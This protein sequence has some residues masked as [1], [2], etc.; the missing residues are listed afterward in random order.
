MRL[1]A[2][3]LLLASLFAPLSALPA[4]ATPLYA[5]FANPPDSA[6]PRTWWHWMDG[7]VSATGIRSDLAWMKRIGLGGVQQID[8][9]LQTPRIVPERVVYGSPAWQADLRLAASEAERLGLEFAIASSPGWSLTGGP[10]VRPEQAMKKLVWSETTVEGGATPRLPAPP[11]VAGPFQDLAAAPAAGPHPAPGWYRDI[12]VLALPAEAPAPRARSI[13]T[14]GGEDVTQSLSDGRLADPVQLAL[15]ADGATWIDLDVGQAESFRALTLA[16]PAPHGFGAPPLPEVM[17]QAS[18]DGEHYTDV[19]PIPLSTAP[20]QTVGFAPHTARWWRVLLKTGPEGGAPPAAPGVLL[21]PFGQPARAFPLSEVALHTQARVHRVEEKAGFAASGDYYALDTAPGAPGVPVRDIVDL[22]ARLRPDGSLD[23][24]AP[25]GRWTVLRFGYS[26]TGKENGPAPVEGTGLEVDKLNAGHVARYM[27]TYLGKLREAVGPGLL[28]RH[29]VRALL[30][31]SIESGF[32]NWTDGMQAAFAER[33]GYSPLR[34]LPAVTGRIVDDAAASDRFLWDLRRTIAELYADGH[35]ATVARRSHAAGLTVYGEAL[36]DNRPQLGDD[37]DMRR[38]ADIP[39]GAMWTVPPS[40]QPRPTFVADLQGAASVAHV[41]GQNL[42][43]AE[44]M[45]AFGQPWAYAPRDLKKT[46]DIE[47]ALGV[48]RIV[49]HTSAHQPLDGITPGMSL[50]PFLGQ[51]FSRH[52]TW[53]GQ[54]RPWIDYLARTSFMLQQ[55]RG[56]ADVAYFYG[57]DAPITGLFGTR[58]NGDVPAGY[59]F[60]YVNPEALLRQFS[61]AGGQLASRSGARY[62]VLYLGGSSSRMTLASLRR[63]AELAR[64]GAA[65]VGRRPAGSPSLADAPAEF[66]RL[67]DQLWGP[68]GGTPGLRRVGLGSVDGMGDLAAALARMQVRPALRLDGPAD[69]VMAIQRHTPTHELYFVANTGKETRELAALFRD[70]RGAPEIWHPD[71]ACA[72]SAVHTR[73]RDGVRVPLRLAPDESLFVVFPRGGATPGLQSGTAPAQPWKPLDGAWQLAFEAGRGAPEQALAM[74]RLT[75]WNQ[76]EIPGVRYFSGTATYRKTFSVDGALP[77][78][79]IL[80]LGEVR[81]LARVRLNGRELGIAW[82]PPY[83]FDLGALP[84]LLRPGEN[85]LEVEVTN[86]WVNRLVGDAQPGAVKVSGAGGIY[87]ANAPL[88]DS[89]MLG[90][91]QLLSAPASGCVEGIAR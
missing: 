35:Y 89:G 44:S 84:G 6:R 75:P 31:D 12:A 83:R 48:N 23:W 58:P 68:A 63:I 42:V 87:A 21:P 1:N 85:R 18:A 24:I 20:Q 71:S 65:V 9:S 56:V 27:D 5:G 64:A 60:D 81:D 78:R 76:S 2:I 37:M 16:L 88:R 91:V 82:K 74:E 22:S 62:R 73:G 14:R 46:A 33:R 45:T 25:P 49:I 29:G 11:A 70:A 67:A 17:L 72:A 4:H 28:G 39:M 53:A 3:G 57:E 19:A 52:E 38:H 66:T 36:E 43:A 59:G 40:G 77:A 32:Q 54:A 90:P 55:G 13:R 86:L 79:A 61:V 7:N 10:W 34:W 30:N 80:D 26:L 8:A 47:F 50:A 41:W 69:G 51:Y 15:G